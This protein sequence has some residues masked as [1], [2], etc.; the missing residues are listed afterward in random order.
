MENLDDIIIQALNRDSTF[1]NITG[2]SDNTCYIF[3]VHAYTVN[4]YGEWR[5]ISN[6]TLR[7]TPLPSFTTISSSSSSLIVQTS[8]M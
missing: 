5:V 4:G 7:I 1:I 8:G 2:L 6:E 3:G